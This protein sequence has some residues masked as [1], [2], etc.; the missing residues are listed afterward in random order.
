MV[1]LYLICITVRGTVDPRLSLIFRT[2]LWISTTW[3]ALRI[4]VRVVWT[5]TLGESWRTYYDTGT[6]HLQ[7]DKV[8][9]RLMTLLYFWWVS[10][11]SCVW[12]T[13]QFNTTGQGRLGRCLGSNRSTFMNG[14]ML[15][16]KGHVTVRVFLLAFCVLPCDDRTGKTPCSCSTMLVDC[17]AFIDMRNTFPPKTFFFISTEEIRRSFTVKHPTTPLLPTVV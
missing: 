14:L 7:V 3:S 13:P 15:K 5:F 4:G 9:G 8:S 12:I 10:T 11:K 2:Q 6:N 16:S 17:L 1:K